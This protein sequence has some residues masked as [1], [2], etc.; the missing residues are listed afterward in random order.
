MYTFEC[1]DVCKGCCINDA[2]QKLHINCHFTV[3]FTVKGHY[4][5]AMP[6]MPNKSGTRV[7]F[8]MEGLN[9]NKIR[10]V[11]TVVFEWLNTP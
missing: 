2:E 1:T 4:R 11:Y 8:Q 9:R 7:P 3:V 10:L 6:R 5:Q